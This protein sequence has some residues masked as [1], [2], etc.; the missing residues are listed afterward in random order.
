MI[1]FWKWFFKV[2]A[3]DEYPAG[4]GKEP[5]PKGG[6]GISAYFDKWLFL[7]VTIGFL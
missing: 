1:N 2:D 4:Q 3:G 6:A 7:H 5:Y